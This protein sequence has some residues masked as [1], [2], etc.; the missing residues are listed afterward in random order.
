MA[1]ALSASI[2]NPAWERRKMFISAPSLTVRPKASRN[3]KRGRSFRKRLKAL[4]I[5][6]QRMN[7]RSKRRRRGDSGRRSF[8]ARAAMRAT[9]GEAPVANDMRL[10][11]RDLDLVIFAD[12][13]HVGARRHSP[14]AELAMPR[15]M[16]AEFVGIVGQPTVVRLMPVLGPH[17]R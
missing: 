16:I 2:L 12:Q 13:L 9:A 14:A 7:A 11:R 15:S 5:N 8:D 10:D 1:F 3:K 6:R 4:Q 17:R